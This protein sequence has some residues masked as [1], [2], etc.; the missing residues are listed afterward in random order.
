[1]QILLVTGKDA[2]D[3]PAGEAGGGQGLEGEDG[4]GQ[5]ALHV[6]HAGAV[7]EAVFVD[8]EGIG[9][10]GPLLEH[11]VHMADEQQGS[12]G[13]VAVPLGHQHAAGVLHR[14]HPDLGANALQF[15]LENRVHSGHTLQLAGA[16]LGVDHLLPEGQ[17]VVVVFVHIPAD[18]FKQF[19][20]TNSSFGFVLYQ[21]QHADD[22]AGDEHRGDGYRHKARCQHLG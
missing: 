17:H 8:A 9:R 3:R 19:L 6:Q 12:L 7:G 20:H 10:D 5:A 15:A 2:L 14:E 22:H 16:A 4:D 21:L 18:L 13:A 11:G 1:M